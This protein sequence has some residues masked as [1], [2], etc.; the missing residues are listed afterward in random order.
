MLSTGWNHWINARTACFF[1]GY[2]SRLYFSPTK[3]FSFSFVNLLFAVFPPNSEVFSS[4]L[5]DS[6]CDQLAT[7]ALSG[8][9]N[10]AVRCNT[11]W[12]LGI[13]NWLGKSEYVIMGDHLDTS[14]PMITLAPHLEFWDAWELEM[15]IQALDWAWK[16]K[17][18]L[19]LLLHSPWGGSALKLHVCNPPSSKKED[20]PTP[21]L[22]DAQMGMASERGSQACPAPVK[23]Y[24]WTGCCF[25]VV[26][27]RWM[28]HSNRLYAL[29]LGEIEKIKR[30]EREFSGRNGLDVDFCNT[31]SV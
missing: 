28:M 13:Q 3:F 16:G 17:A 21:Q 31:S 29:L 27:P 23:A 9:V 14:L 30:K 24:L 25:L 5:R 26:R 20:F 1:W 15:A 10:L 18:K 12:K 19:A 8:C 4:H 6:H 11:N 22:W 2:R 7:A